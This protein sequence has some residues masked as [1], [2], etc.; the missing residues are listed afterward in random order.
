MSV[1]NDFDFASHAVRNVVALHGFEYALFEKVIV[2]FSIAWR[3][4]SCLAN[5][6]GFAV[7][8][9]HIGFVVCLRSA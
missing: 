9:V 7:A 4:K 6:E 8:R 1:P 3:F 5:I 2:A